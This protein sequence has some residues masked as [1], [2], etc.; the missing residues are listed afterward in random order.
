MHD[1][2]GCLSDEE[3]WLNNFW[4]QFKSSFPL[5]FL[6]TSLNSKLLLTFISKYS[7]EDFDLIT[8]IIQSIIIFMLKYCDEKYFLLDVIQPPLSSLVQE[9]V[10][11]CH[12]HEITVYYEY[13]SE[14]EF[15]FFFKSDSIFIY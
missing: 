13:L 14:G 6:I 5:F 9:A 2:Q 1:S 3:V 8:C 12:T 11:I 7:D 4:I 15:Q 10:H